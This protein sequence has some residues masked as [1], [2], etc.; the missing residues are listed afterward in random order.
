MECYAMQVKLVLQKLASVNST[1]TI[2]LNEAAELLAKHLSVNLCRQGT[3]PR[4]FG[5]VS[6]S[7]TTDALLVPTVIMCVRL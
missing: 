2:A 3:I 1:P 7:L 4:M 6:I 5:H